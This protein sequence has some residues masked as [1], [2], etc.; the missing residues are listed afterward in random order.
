MPTANAHFDHIGSR[1][2]GQPLLAGL[3]SRLSATACGDEIVVKLAGR[4]VRIRAPA[5]DLSSEATKSIWVAMGRNHCSWLQRKPSF[6]L[7][8]MDG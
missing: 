4:K 7:T 1:F 8:Q 2:A 3:A 6:Y 5:K